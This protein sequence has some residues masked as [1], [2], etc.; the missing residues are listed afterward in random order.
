MGYKWIVTQL[1]ATL[2]NSG[3]DLDGGS[4]SETNVKE[5][6]AEW[7]GASIFVK[8]I[9]PGSDVIITLEA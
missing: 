7:P 1:C 4:R 9:A 5:L 8:V 6:P 3:I 2:F